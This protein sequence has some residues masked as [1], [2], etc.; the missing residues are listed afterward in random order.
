LAE[1]LSSQLN[2]ASYHA[3]EVAAWSAETDNKTVVH[4]ITSVVKDD[5][6][7]RGSVLA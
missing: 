7:R 3:G 6:D 2:A 1:S 4:G 5:R